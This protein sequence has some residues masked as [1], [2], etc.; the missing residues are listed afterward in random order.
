MQKV[1]S[2][3]YILR[4]YLPVLPL[5]DEEYTEKRFVE[6][7]EFCKDAKVEAVMFFVALAPYCCYW[8]EEPSLTEAWVE[9]MKPYIERLQAE[10]ISY[11]LNFQNT[12]GAVPTGEGMEKHF[13][14][15]HL[16]DQSGYISNC[17]CPMGVKFRK[18]T[19]KRLQYWA[20]TKPDVIWLDDDF[21]MHGHNHGSHLKTKGLAFYCYCDEHIRL[22]NKKYNNAEIAF[23]QVG[24]KLN[25]EIEKAGKIKIIS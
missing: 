9:Q 14:W 5:Y 12:L 6:L 2:Y 21:R 13:D 10:G 18:N 23:E 19:G 20:R 11:Q 3:P 17:G 16:V 7:L 22:F 4:Y 8:P 15:E 1:K 25:F 24:K